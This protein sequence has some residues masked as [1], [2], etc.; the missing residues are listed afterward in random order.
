MTVGPA[1]A[2]QWDVASYSG[3]G[4]YGQNLL[5]NWSRRYD[6]TIACSRAINR[7]HLD[8]DPLELLL[9]QPAI[10]RS[11][12]LCQQLV[13][14]AGATI[15]APF[16]LLHGLTSGFEPIKAA[17]GVHLFGTPSIGIIFIE[18]DFVPKEARERAKAYPLIVAGSRWNHEILKA[19]G[20]DQIALV[21]QGID[22]THF[23]LAPRA[24]TFGGRFTIFSGG[25]LETRKGQDLVLRAF[26]VFA[27][28]HPDAL[29]MTAWGSPWP[30]RSLALNAQSVLRPLQLTS[31][32]QPDTLAW[33]SENGI[34]AHQ[35]L[36]FGPLPNS[37]I[38]R[39]LREADAALFASRVEGGTNLAAM[40]AMACGLPTILSAGSGHLDLIAGGNCFPLRRQT[41]VLARG[42]EGWHESDPEEIVDVLESIYDQHADAVARGRRAA[43]EIAEFTWGRQLG[44]LADIVLPYARG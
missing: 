5:L 18:S 37:R 42:C 39:I 38:A 33:T 44:R 43:A 20:I 17:H 2:F 25:K 14:Y 24:G 3:W 36:H 31:D 26:K 7:E 6:L 32:G 15:Q 10:E 27:Q 29:L 11:E 35:V 22:Q 1:V 9:L 23:H 12:Q 13:Q 19:A 8:L 4:V 40:E 30:E 16:T 21:L 34:P 28:R 41:P